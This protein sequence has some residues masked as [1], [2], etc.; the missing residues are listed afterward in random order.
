[1]IRAL[2][3]LAVCAGLASGLAYLATSPPPLVSQFSN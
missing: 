3:F 1:M 2:F